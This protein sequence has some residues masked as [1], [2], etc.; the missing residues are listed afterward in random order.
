LLVGVVSCALG[1]R[2]AGGSV[3]VA[4]ATTNAVVSGIFLII[5]VDAA[6]VTLQ[7]L[8]FT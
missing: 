4:R 6:F 7:R 3:G 1:L 5:V 8:L 2:V